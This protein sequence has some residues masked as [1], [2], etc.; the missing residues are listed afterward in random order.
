MPGVRGR[1]RNT[2]TRLRRCPRTARS[3]PDGTLRGVH[4]DTLTKR[5]LLVFAPLTRAR[6]HER[7][8]TP[9]PATAPVSTTFGQLAPE[10]H[11]GCGRVLRG[12]M[13]SRDNSLTCKNASDSVRFPCRDGRFPLQRR[14]GLIC[15]LA[16]GQ[17]I[18]GSRR[19]VPSIG[20]ARSDLR[21]SLCGGSKAS[22]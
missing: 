12:K 9:M 1:M 8:S 5:G 10:R 16:A 17:Q 13:S 2:I 4:R 18:T 22:S 20:Q 3:P 15:G 19:R 7:V 11:L 6:T 21:R 14:D